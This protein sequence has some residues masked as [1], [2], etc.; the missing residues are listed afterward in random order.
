MNK[1]FVYDIPVSTGNYNDYVNSCLKE[2]GYSCFLNVHMVCE[3]HRNPNFQDVL[4]EAA[5]VVPDGMPLVFSLRLFHRIKQERI[6]G[7]DIM[8]SLID[9]AR[10]ES[11][12]VFLIGST[13]EILATISSQLAQ[14]NVEHQTYSPPFLPI[15]EFNFDHQAA[16]ISEYAP[17]MVLVG[18][19]CPKQEIWMN[20]MKDKVEAPMFGVGGAFLLFAGIDKRA[21]QWMRKLSLEWFYR[22]LLEPKRLFKRYLTTNSYFLWL[23]L[24]QV[25]S[26]RDNSK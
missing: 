4:K 8:Q 7:N 23:M 22:F 5:Y 14:I 13:E 11:L 17:D 18:L 10:L 25:F 21:P 24:K 2:K 15:E 12:K 3:H 16:I 19:G 26:K 1:E 20:R 9:K 6:A